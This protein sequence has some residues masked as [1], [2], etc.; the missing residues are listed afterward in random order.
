MRNSM[1]R[2]PFF[3]RLKPRRFTDRVLKERG[4]SR[5]DDR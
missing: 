2:I 1:F 5:V 3:L 4:F